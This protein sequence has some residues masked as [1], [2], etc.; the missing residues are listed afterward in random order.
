MTLVLLGLPM[1]APQSYRPGTV[2]TWLAFR[3]LLGLSAAHERERALQ[4]VS[5]TDSMGAT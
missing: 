2:L 3:A 4:K 1:D 5:H